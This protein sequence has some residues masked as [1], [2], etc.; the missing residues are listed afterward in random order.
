[1]IKDILLVTDNTALSDPIILA[2]VAMA[3]RLTCDLTIDILTPDPVLFPAISPFTTMD[4]PKADMGLDEAARVKAILAMAVSSSA[5]VRVV[6]LHD[7]PSG[8]ARRAG[9]SGPIADLIVMGDADVWDTLWLRR[10]TIETTIM[11]AGTPLLILGGAASFAPIHHAV[12]GWKDTAEARRAVHDLV[13]LAEPGA[14]IAVVGIAPDETGIAQDRDS[15]Q[16]VVRHLR[17]HGFD[18]EAH[19]LLDNGRSDAEALEGFALRQGAQ[20]LAIGAFGHS[21]LHEVVFGGVTRSLIERPR[22][23]LL[24]S[25]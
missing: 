6:G 9:K 14:R 17:R 3:E 11:G 4:L 8:L 20:V 13:A 23:P 7:S 2:A 24:L 19:A 5:H 25:H 10:R 21:R 16:D 15:A 1:M 18:A 22:L 12:L